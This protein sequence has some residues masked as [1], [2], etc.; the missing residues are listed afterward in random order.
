[1]KPA[2]HTEDLWNAIESYLLDAKRA[3]TQEIR[4]YPQP[5]AGCDAQIPALW[6]QRDGIVAELEI[7]ASARIDID[8]DI[9]T[10]IAQCSFID[11]T[12]KQAFFARLEPGLQSAAE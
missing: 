5:I 4:S 3:A 6:E 8:S 11:D 1:M 9:D 10:F 12:Q 7:L 2:Q